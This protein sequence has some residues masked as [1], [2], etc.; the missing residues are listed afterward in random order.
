MSIRPERFLLVN[1]PMKPLPFKRV[2]VEFPELLVSDDSPFL[3]PRI[4]VAE[5][6]SCLVYS[7][8]GVVHRLFD[9]V[10]A[11]AMTV[12]LQDQDCVYRIGELLEPVSFGGYSHVFSNEDHDLM[13]VGLDGSLRVEV[14]W[15]DELCD[16]RESLN[17]VPMVVFPADEPDLNTVRFLRRLVG[18]V[19]LKRGSSLY[20]GNGLV[21]I[22]APDFESYI[23]D[24]GLTVI[25]PVPD[26]S[27]DLPVLVE[28]GCFDLDSVR[29][30]ARFDGRWIVS[31]YS[32]Q[33]R[34]ECSLQVSDGL[35]TL[36]DPRQLADALFRIAGNGGRVYGLVDQQ[37]SQF[38]SPGQ[39]WRGCPYWIL[40]LF[41]LLVWFRFKN[42]MH[43]ATP[44]ITQNLRITE[45]WLPRRRDEDQ[46]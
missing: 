32:D 11:P 13:L 5:R 26:S 4:V 33:D 2:R 8:T 1:S 10:Q 27:P 22:R 44:I 45:L 12:F 25:R 21:V 9:V 46:A 19:P 17:N 37:Y 39:T 18:T 30:A 15:L 34:I 31:D 14:R 7:E 36:V 16:V 28:L 42:R 6:G 41:T 29:T 20:R 38:F 43:I 23:S 40:N 24:S 3:Y 35:S